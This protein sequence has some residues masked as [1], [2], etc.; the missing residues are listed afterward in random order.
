MSYRR[1]KAADLD[2]LVQIEEA[3]FSPA[4]Y[5]RMPR[6]QFRAH[7][8]SERA[9]LIVV[10]DVNGIVQGYALGFRH[11]QRRTL[12]FYS[13]AVDPLAQ[14]GEYGKILFQGIEAE[15]YRLGLG[16]QCEVRADN[17]KLKSRYDSLGY[18]AYKTVPEYY[19][20]GAACIKYEKDATE[21]A[22]IFR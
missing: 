20:D 1:A 3:S 13:L 10:E 5:S 9:V 4:L 19:P 14:R 11:A 7:I 2:R 18:R 16:V 12:R 17:D 8:D 6:R 15:A 22:Q 21:I